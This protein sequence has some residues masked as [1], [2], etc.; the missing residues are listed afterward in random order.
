MAAALHDPN[1][2]L[3]QVRQTVISTD[4]ST[5]AKKMFLLY[6]LLPSSMVALP[7]LGFSPTLSFATCCMLQLVDEHY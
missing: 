7:I 2:H 4:A 3:L 6:I 5:D 1:R